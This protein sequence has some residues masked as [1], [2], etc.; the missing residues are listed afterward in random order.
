M[1][2]IRPFFI[3]IFICV[4]I[5]LSAQVEEQKTGTNEDKP[6]KLSINDIKND[7]LEK[8]MVLYK[9]SRPVRVDYPAGTKVIFRMKDDKK[10]EYNQIIQTV[11][12]SSFVAEGSNIMYKDVYSIKVYRNK[13]FLKTFQTVFCFGGGIGYLLID[14]VNN[15]FTTTPETL[16]V[17]ASFLSLGGILTFFVKPRKYKLNKNRYLKTLRKW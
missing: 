17:S 4:F 8:F 7:T 1:N 16:T 3:S 12:D 13:P 6:K 9:L 11:L 5:T 2:L 14:L 10:I 15:S